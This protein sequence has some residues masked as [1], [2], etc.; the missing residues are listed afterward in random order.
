MQRTWPILV[1][2]TKGVPS[3]LHQPVPMCNLLLHWIRASLLWPRE[4]EEGDGMWLPRVVKKGHCSFRSTLYARL[5]A[6]DP[7]T[8]S[9]S[10]LSP[11]LFAEVLAGSKRQPMTRPS[12]GSLSHPDL[13]PPTFVCFHALFRIDLTAVQT[14]GTTV[15]GNRLESLSIWASRALS[16]DCPSYFEFKL[17]EPLR[18]R[19]S[20][21][22]DT[23]NKVQTKQIPPLVKSG[24]WHFFFDWGKLWWILETSPTKIAG[25]HS[26]W[27]TFS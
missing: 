27:P 3:H 16:K 25:F 4:Y 11:L 15:K 5:P 13:A 6:Q 26:K 7:L 24:H 9:P 22:L 20:R 10:P 1:A 12:P 18:K 17:E 8:S 23:V 2:V 14:T 21:S 19:L